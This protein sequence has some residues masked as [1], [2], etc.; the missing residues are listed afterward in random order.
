[1]QFKCQKC[2]S[3]ITADNINIQNMIGKCLACNEIS[4]LKVGA[5]V[6]DKPSDSGLMETPIGRSGV[7]IAF[8]KYKSLGIFF[9]LFGGV[10]VF[11]SGFMLWSMVYS[12]QNIDKPGL[13]FISFFLIFGLSILIFGILQLLLKVTLIAERR[14]LKLIKNYVIFERIKEID[15]DENLEINWVVRY[16]QNRVPVYGAKIIG[17]AN[18]SFT[19]GINLSENEVYWLRNKLISVLPSAN[20]TR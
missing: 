7:A 5:D 3:L 10:W 8:P 12:Q 1:M 9:I 17:L 4:A 18:N 13:I 2:G 16:T 11:I 6:V 15:Y 14:K 20:T 19:V